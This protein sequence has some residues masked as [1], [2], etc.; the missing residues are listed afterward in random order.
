MLNLQMALCYCANN[1]D[2]PCRLN[3]IHIPCNELQK[4]LLVF[5]NKFFQKLIVEYIIFIISNK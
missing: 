5:K 2:T 1:S 4:S 3:Q